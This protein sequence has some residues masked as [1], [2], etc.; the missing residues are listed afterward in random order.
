MLYI[1]EKQESSRT[2]AQNICIQVFLSD[3]L[4]PQENPSL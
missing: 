4:V 2:S 3:I 1:Y